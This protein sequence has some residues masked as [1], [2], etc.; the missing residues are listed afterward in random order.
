V[1]NICN[2]VITHHSVNLLTALGDVSLAIHRISGWTKLKLHN[3]RSLGYA[4][5]CEH[6]GATMRQPLPLSQ[7]WMPLTKK[8][9]G[10]TFLHRNHR[11]VNCCF[12]FNKDWRQDAYRIVRD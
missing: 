10:D 7:N 12:T 2:S 6:S 1:Y 9:L 3:Q 4:A 8:Q 5:S 11:V